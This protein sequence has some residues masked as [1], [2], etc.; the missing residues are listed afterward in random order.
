MS[1][2]DEGSTMPTQNEA[3]ALEQQAPAIPEAREDSGS[4][5]P[6]QAHGDPLRPDGSE[7]DRLEQD[8]DEGL[9]AD[10]D[11]YPRGSAG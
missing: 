6:V 11:D 7:A 2:T 5:D 9:P 8:A 3:D 1:T 10:E 4:R